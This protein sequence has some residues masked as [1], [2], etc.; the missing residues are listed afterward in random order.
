MT[1]S[2]YPSNGT[3]LASVHSFREGTRDA[4]EF[5]SDI[6][7][8]SIWDTTGMSLYELTDTSLKTVEPDA[9]ITEINSSG[10]TGPLCDTAADGFTALWN[11]P[12]EIALDETISFRILWCGNTDAAGTGH[13]V[14]TIVYKHLVNG[15]TAVAV[16]ATALDTTVATATGDQSNLAVYVPQFTGWGSISASTLIAAVPGDAAIALKCT[17]TNLDGCTDAV[18]LA[19]QVRYYRRWIG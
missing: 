16:P 7:Y 5:A 19:L 2:F 10:I 13:P 14:W 8:R 11:L 3:G 9:L 1:L 4:K 17:C 6:V 18:P 12:A 15:T